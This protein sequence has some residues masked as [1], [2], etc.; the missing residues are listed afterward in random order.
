MTGVGVGADHI[1][2]PSA[3][4]VIPPHDEDNRI[5]QN[6]DERVTTSGD[7]RIALVQIP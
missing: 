7:Q 3:G 5:T 6:L 1:N 4:G 2:A